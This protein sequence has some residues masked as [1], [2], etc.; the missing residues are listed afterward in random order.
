MY[1][2]VDDENQWLTLLMLNHLSPRSLTHKLLYQ[3]K[4]TPYK[5]KLTI[6]YFP[7]K[8]LVSVKPHFHKS[9]TPRSHLLGSQ[10]VERL[11]YHQMFLL[12]LVLLCL[13]W[14]QCC[15]SH[16]EWLCGW[17][18]FDW[19]WRI[20]IKLVL[21]RSYHFAI[22]KLYRQFITF[23]FSWQQKYSQLLTG[24]N[25]NV[26]WGLFLQSTSDGNVTMC[27]QESNSLVWKEDYQHV[28]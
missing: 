15:C 10:F 5:I 23:I 19:D 21:T 7:V 28:W 1:A 24:H 20:Y 27:I 25:F 6:I 8:T 26:V 4:I 13:W 9:R 12:R 3:F 17:T 16:S 22:C 2:N 18:H 11:F 14:L